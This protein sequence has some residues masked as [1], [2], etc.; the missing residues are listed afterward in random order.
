M[1]LHQVAKRLYR[2]GGKATVLDADHQ[3]TPL[4]IEIGERGGTSDTGN[5]Q[6][7]IVTPDWRSD[8]VVHDAHGRAAS[9]YGG[10]IAAMP[11]AGRQR[12]EELPVPRSYRDR[13]RSAQ[14]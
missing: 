3:I 7:R 14:G 9:P 5:N 2:L 13:A 10:A 11:W 8:D 1:A 12:I 6:S 4:A